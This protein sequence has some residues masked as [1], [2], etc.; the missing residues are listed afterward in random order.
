[1]IKTFSTMIERYNQKFKKDLWQKI[2]SED[3]IV[4]YFFDPGN[5]VFINIETIMEV[6]AVSAVKHS[7]LFD[8][9]FLL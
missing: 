5:Q 1:M 3:L 9:M 2:D 4:N 6:L 8:R 7:I